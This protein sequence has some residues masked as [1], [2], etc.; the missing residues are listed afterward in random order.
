MASDVVAAGL[1]FRTNGYVVADADNNGTLT[2]LD[3]PN[4][5]VV[6]AGD[7]AV[8]SEVLAGTNGFN[9]TGAGR[10]QLTAANTFTG[11]VTVKAGTLRLTSNVSAVL[12]AT[13]VGNET[14][15]EDGA[16]LD[17]YSAYSGSV[18]EDIKIKGSG[19]GGA[20]AFVNNGPTAYYNVGYRNLTLLGDATIGG[21]QRFDMSGNGAYYGNGYTLTKVG[22]CEIAVGRAVTNSPI[23]IGG[24][25]YTIQHAQALGD[26]DY[27]T[28]LNSGAKLQTWGGYTLAERLIINGGTLSASGTSINLF[29]LTGNVTFNSNVVVQTDVST[30]NAVEFS[31]VLDGVGGFT[32]SGSGFVYVTGDANTYSGPTTVSSGSKLWVGRTVG[33]TGVLGTGFTTNSGTLYANS[34]NLS[35]GTV[36]NA[37]GGALYLNPAT[38]GVGRVFN[39]SG[40]TVYGTSVVQAA[41]GVVNAGTWNAYSGSFGSSAVTNASGG[42][43]NLYT[44]QLVYGSF[45]NGGTLSLWQSMTLA[46]PLTFIGGT[47]YVNDLSNALAVTAPIALAGSAT[48]S[49]TASSSTEV[50]GLLSGPGGLI[51][52]GDGWCYILN[53]GNNYSGPTIVNDSK[54]LFVGKAGVTTAGRL[55]SGAITNNGTLFFDHAGAYEIANGLN[56]YGNTFIRY[57]A[58]LTVN[59]KVST[60][61][62]IRLAQGSLSLVNGASLCIPADFTVA[63]RQTVS[64]GVYPTNSPLVTNVTAIVNVADGC[65]LTVSSMTF[66]NG[67]DLPNGTMTGILNQVGGTVRTTGYTAEENG[68]RLGHYPMTRSFYNMMGGTLI[69][70]ANYDLGCATDGQGWF[71]MSGGEVFTKR[72]MLNERD[73]TG[74]YGRLTVSGG[75]LN[76]GSLSGSTVAF[77]NGICADATAPYLV[78]LGGAGGTIRAVTN[79]W[80]PVAAT[81]YG[82]GTNAV[83]LD[84]REWAISMTNRLSG[85]GGLNKAGTGTLLLAGNNG[86]TGLTQVA[87]GTLQL[88]SATAL[89]NAVALVV[90]PGATVDLG[91]FSVTVSGVSGAGVVSNGQLTVTGAIAPGTNGVGELTFALTDA[92]PGGTLVVE[93]RTDGTCDVLHATG[94]LSL[95]GMSLQVVDDGQLNRHKIYTIA[96][97]DGAL[98]GRFGAKSLP[99]PWFV[100]YDYSARA[101]KLSA[102][103]GT[104]IGVQ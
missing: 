23:V 71:N 91:G 32:R 86:F 74:G 75:T 25:I 73:N 28:T 64:Y 88:G 20:G 70:G 72:V 97:S 53:D 66:G 14:V 62:V 49:G 78:E 26:T 31:G 51:R 103:V 90:A 102:R 85:S 94:N 69:V 39:L 83:T 37:S 7:S 21:S 22:G 15:V 12:G 82:S 65:T 16:T 38:L 42:T 101:V 47:L 40:G 77:S 43:L 80:I 17:Q 67:G 30:T 35:A 96:R 56:G 4:I 68:V 50:S 2:L 29:K 19:V 100:F 33:G 46:S 44:N 13:G 48:L 89:S 60:N 5:E 76:V 81:L 92:A 87:A 58:N 93:A 41:G 3:K 45:A 52:A 24:G 18:N 98:T 27:P 34:A 9:K 54:R 55:G 84:S 6:N 59:G 95:N 1:S 63:D 79:L 61:N 11:V 36:V 99:S 57:G 104:L 10:L 8:I